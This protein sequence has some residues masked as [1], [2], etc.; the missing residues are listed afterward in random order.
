M[1]S[2]IDCEFSRRIDAT[3]VKTI[4]E[5]GSRD[6]HDAVKLYSVYKCPVYAFECNEDCLK[7]CDQTI[8]SMTNDQRNAIHLERSAVTTSDGPVTFYSFDLTKYNNMGASSMLKIDFKQRDSRD[9]DYG[10]PNPQ[11]AIQVPGIR[12]DT[13]MTKN[14]V[15]AI[16]LLCMDLQGYELMALHSLGTQIRNVKYIITE[17]QM[18]TTY[19]GGVDWKDLYMFLSLNGFVYVYSDIFGE[20]LPSDSNTY[21]D[22][23]VLFRRI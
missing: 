7:V 13:F 2:Y 22:F 18:K 15:S 8:Q 17:C 6:L 23:N 14:G 1:Q 3:A 19:T 9:G 11:K 4:F 12:L 20:N 10:L 21:C 5:V 16:D